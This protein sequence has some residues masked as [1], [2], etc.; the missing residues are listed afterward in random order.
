MIGNVEDADVI[1]VGLGAM[2]SSALWRLAARGVPVLG[3]EQ[4]TSGSDRGGSHGESRI[5]RTAYAEGAKYVPLVREAWR[6]WRELE[7]V[8]GVELLYR[9]GALSLGP[10]GSPRATGPIAAAREY[11]L[12]YESLS[13]SEIRKRF[14]QLVVPDGHGGV[15]D[16]DAGYLRAEAAIEAA[17]AAA[18]AS[19]ARVLEGTGVVRVVAD[20]D[21]P[22]VVLADGRRLTA[23]H[24]VV[25]A[26][27]WLRN[28]VP[29]VGRHVRV[30]RR[31]M[32][33]FRV[34]GAGSARDAYAGDSMPVFMGGDN[35][36]NDWY[37]FPSVDGETVK[38]GLHVWSEPAEEVDLDRGHRPP[39]AADER[40]FA[41]IAERVLVGVD[42]TPVRMTA[43]MQD[44]TPDGDFLVGPHRDAPGLTLLGGF[45]G[46]GFKFAS[47]LGDVAAD[48]AVSGRTPR[49]IRAFDPHRFDGLAV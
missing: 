8:S 36:G 10:A 46:H 24:V 4:F 33:W 28:L 9:T 22:G 16:A 14:P 21:R 3:I 17:V 30:E 44:H 45:S 6:L 25:A 13:G 39:D 29:S 19:G 32:A 41:A 27:G 15:L 43:C 49:D 31:V 12:A 37:G 42:P 48:F 5:I 2:G 18:R 40:R 47:V 23:R 11:G 1:V 34:P 7:R 38:L 26:G 20:A 35:V